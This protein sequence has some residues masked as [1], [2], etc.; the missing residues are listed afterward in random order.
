M[1]KGNLLRKS[2]FL[3]M[4]LRHKPEE[5]NLKMDKH[6]WISVDELVKN[7]NISQ[8]E[9]EEIVR[10]DDKERYSF[11]EDKKMVRANQGHSIPWVEIEFEEVSVDDIMTLGGYLYHGTGKQ[12][13]QSILKNGINK[14]DRNY[15]HLS[16]DVKTA[17]K[18]GKRHGEP[19]VFRVKALDMLKEGWKIYK[20]KNGVYL[21]DFV[22]I[23][24]LE[25]EN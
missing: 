8:E 20:S 16:R 22:V 23:K 3:S 18:V 2:K 17:L 14:G 11:S 9:L 6:G 7:T 15:V 5:A 13:K 12:N 25:D 19:I 21:V 4:L 1:G 10:T 24:Y